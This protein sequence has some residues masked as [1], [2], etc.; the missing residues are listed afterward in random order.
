MKKKLVINA[1]VSETR[2]A[3]LEEGKVAELYVERH[4]NKGM[5]GNIYKAKV[6]RV[7]PG[8]QSAFINIGVDQSAFLFGGDVMDPAFIKALKEQKDSKP[9][10]EN[11]SQ[12]S[13]NRT[14]IENIIR[15][16]QEIMIQVA[17]EPLGTKGPRVTMQ[18]A[19]PG[20]Y[21]VL[22]PDFNNLGISRRIEDEAQREEIRKRVETIKPPDMGLIV[23]TAAADVDV[24]LLKKDLEYLQ[25]VWKNIKEK[26]L[27]RSAPA[28]LYQEPDLV[29]KTTR[30]LYS[31]EI[32][33]IVVDDPAAYSQLKHFLTDTIPGSDGK[34]S[35]YKKPNPVFDEYGIEMDIAKALARKVWLPSGGYLVIDQTE[36]L[37][38][39]DVNTGK[40]VGS[41]N[42]Q[43]TILE[44][45]LEAAQEIVSQLRIRNLGGIIVIDFI[46]M[47][48]LEDRA[49]V[50]ARMEEA[51][52]NDK[53][54]TNM[55]PMNDLCII[56]LTRKRTSESLERILTEICPYCDGRGRVHSMETI[57]YDLARDIERHVLRTGQKDIRLKVREDIKEWL[58]NEENMLLEAIKEKHD[59]TIRFE[60]SD[61]NIKLLY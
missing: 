45:N 47:E 50:N 39:F 27:R 24:S 22:M 46:D 34:L 32:S 12:Y 20:R 51:L 35:L 29:V 13:I 3:L 36:A 55:L 7:L 6:T 58:I 31:E 38:S 19:I 11:D 44:T 9:N 8:M 43:S 57:I 33:E 4:S 52:K 61:L 21:L 37:T 17:K 53:A 54:R 26:S 1:N 2:I 14:P 40:N 49:K 59:I 18:I 41:S 15:N 23:R 28:L 30:D 25:E 10:E 16:G 56:E 5:V 48:N 60:I 42:V